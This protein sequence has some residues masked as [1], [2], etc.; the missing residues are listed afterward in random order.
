MIGVYKG[1]YDIIDKLLGPLHQ[2]D[3]EKIPLKIY[4]CDR[5]PV[6]ER[7]F[8][9]GGNWA[10]FDCVTPFIRQQLTEYRFLPYDVPIKVSSIN[11]FRL[12]INQFW[13]P[14]SDHNV[15]YGQT[16]M[17]RGDCEFVGCRGNVYHSVRIE[18]S[19]TEISLCSIREDLI[20]EYRDRAL[21]SFKH[22]HMNLPLVR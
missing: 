15:V 9:W 2:D 3:V 16:L 7:E 20:K 21:D 1:S 14:N 19:K 18:F 4:Y 12:S 10:H 8:L 17:C 13:S 5:Y 11:K 22:F 6:T